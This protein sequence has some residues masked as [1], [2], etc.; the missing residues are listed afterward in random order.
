VAP[1]I[2]AHDLH[3]LVRSLLATRAGAYFWGGLLE[4]FGCIVPEED[5]RAP[6]GTHG[7]EGCG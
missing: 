1:S 5:G 7:T 4:V 2:V 6:P 3:Q